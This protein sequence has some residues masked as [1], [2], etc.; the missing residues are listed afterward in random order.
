LL[1]LFKYRI[2]FLLLTAI[3]TDT[4]LFIL[5]IGIFYALILNREST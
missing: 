3:F 4:P 1:L 5:F 2:P